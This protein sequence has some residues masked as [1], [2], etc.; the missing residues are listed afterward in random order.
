MALRLSSVL[1]RSAESWLG[2]Q[3]AYD[4]WQVRKNLDLASLEALVPIQT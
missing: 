1:G 3:H 2:M 4:F